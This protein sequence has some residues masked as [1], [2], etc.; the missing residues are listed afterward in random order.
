MIIRTFKDHEFYLILNTRVGS[1]FMLTF[2]RL[3]FI[4]TSN[5]LEVK[6]SIIFRKSLRI[7]T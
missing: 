4:V 6:L 1:N 3:N 5:V 7:N 2:E